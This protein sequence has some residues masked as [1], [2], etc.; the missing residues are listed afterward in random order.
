MTNLATLAQNKAATPNLSTWVNANAGSGKTRVLNQPS[1]P[2]IIARHRPATD[3][4]PDL[5][6]RR[7]GGNANPI[8]RPFGQLGDV[9][10]RRFA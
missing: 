9:G 3:F 7:G 1:R 4:M 8:V 5:Y 10:R 6:Q 2:I